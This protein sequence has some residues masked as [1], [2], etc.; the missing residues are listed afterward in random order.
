MAKLRSPY[1]PFTPHFIIGPIGQAAA[2]TQ[3]SGL[4]LSWT[5]SCIPL[6]LRV[7]HILLPSL[8]IL[9]IL[10]PGVAAAEVV[11]WMYLKGELTEFDA[12]LEERYEKEVLRVDA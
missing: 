7:V 8:G 4:C 1:D 11:R 3:E 6:C 2:Q 5:F 12:G 9:F 10:L